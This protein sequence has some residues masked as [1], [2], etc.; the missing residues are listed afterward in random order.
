MKD[1]YDY[2]EKFIKD[3]YEVS[4][5]VPTVKKTADTK[6]FVGN[7][8]SLFKARGSLLSSNVLGK[9]FSLTIDDSSI[10]NLLN[11]KLSRRLIGDLRAVVLDG[12]VRTRVKTLFIGG[13]TVAGDLVAGDSAH[14]LLSY[15]FGAYIRTLNDYPE[16]NGGKNMLFVPIKLLEPHGKYFRDLM[17]DGDEQLVLPLDLF[18]FVFSK[19]HFLL[20]YVDNSDYKVTHTSITVPDNKYLR[21]VLKSTSLTYDLVGSEII[22]KGLGS[23]L[24]GL[25]AFSMRLFVDVDKKMGEVFKMIYNP[26]ETADGFDEDYKH[27]VAWYPGFIFHRFIGSNYSFKEYKSWDIKT[28]VNGYEG[29]ADAFK[30]LHSYMNRLVKTI[31]LYTNEYS[32]AHV[33]VGSTTYDIPMLTDDFAYVMYKLYGVGEMPSERIDRFAVWDIKLEKIKTKLN[34]FF[35]DVYEE[36]L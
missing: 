17:V 18:D 11:T 35:E 12:I 5:G 26:Q 24:S 19:R 27:F 4:G 6:L 33:L 2:F 1:F 10:G 7:D 13:N 15:L 20:G 28:F 29:E 23:Y 22:V 32:V 16:S 21:L 36:I 8:P 34:T 3:N 14:N 30:R 9:D 25:S 31:G